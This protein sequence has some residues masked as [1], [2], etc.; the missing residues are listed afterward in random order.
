MSLT[1]IDR[2]HNSRSEC[3]SHT[4]KP[5]SAENYL[6]HQMYKPPRTKLYAEWAIWCNTDSVVDRGVNS[7]SCLGTFHRGSSNWAKSMRA[8]LWEELPLPAKW[9]MIC[10]SIGVNREYRVLDWQWFKKSVWS[11]RPSLDLAVDSRI[12]LRMG[13]VAVFPPDVHGKRFYRSTMSI[14]KRRYSFFSFLSNRNV[15]VAHL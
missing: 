2:V 11:I 9:K 3:A 7:F 14:S 1:K 12:T 10:V 5:E 13:L 6:Q 8:S 4:W 15:K